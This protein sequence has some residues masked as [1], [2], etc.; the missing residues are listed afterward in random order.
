MQCRFSVPD[1]NSTQYQLRRQYLRCFQNNAF[2]FY[3]NVLYCPGYKQHGTVYRRVSRR[4]RVTAFS[5]FILPGQCA[6]TCITYYQEMNGTAPVARYVTRGILYR[7]ASVVPIFSGQYTCQT[8]DASTSCARNMSHITQCQLQSLVDIFRMPTRPIRP[9]TYTHWLMFCH[10]FEPNIHW[11]C[12][13]PSPTRPQF[14]MMAQYACNIMVPKHAGR[15]NMFARRRHQCTL[16]G[17]YICGPRVS[18]YAHGMSTMRTWSNR[19]WESGTLLT[20]ES[21][22]L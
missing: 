19:I 17:Q 9:P 6:Y 20:V 7:V 14:M 10:H 5:A 3:L 1:K 21:F 8:P 18:I 11:P 2:A 13:M 16:G 15:I 4:H 22:G 12:N